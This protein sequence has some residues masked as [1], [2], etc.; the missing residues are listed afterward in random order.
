MKIVAV[1]SCISGI[2]HTYMAA[3]ALEEAAKKAGVEIRVETQGSA[4]TTP[5]EADFL[6]DADAAVFAHEL[7]VKDRE[8]FAGLPTVD[9]PVSDAISGA[10]A[11]V[12]KAIAE[13]TEQQKSGAKRSGAAAASAPSAEASATKPSAGKSI[14]NKLMT[15]VSYMIPFVAAGGILIAIGFLL[16]GYLVMNHYSIDGLNDIPTLWANFNFGD[17]TWWGALAFWTGKAA[18]AFLVPVLAGY[19]AYAIADRPGLAPGFVGGSI[20]VTIGA[21]F[22]GG[23]AAGFIGGYAAYWIARIKL[24]RAIDALKPVVI[25]PLIASIVTGF[26]MFTVVGAPVSLLMTA[27][28]D[29]LSSFGSGNL[30]IL[31]LVLGAMMGLDLGGPV[32]KVAYLFATTGLDAGITALQAQSGQDPS[33]IPQLVIMAAVMAAGM[34]PPLGIALATVLQK[35]KFSKAERDNGKAAWLLGASFIS[36]GAIPFAAADPLRILPATIIGSA[37][38]GGLVGIFGASL[39]APHGGIWVIGLIGHPWL[40][41]LA[42]IIGT[43]VTGA[44]VVAAKNIGAAAKSNSAATTPS[45]ADELLAS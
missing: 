18:F 11:L 21:G 4:G 35:N 31:G 41:L 22:L 16:G 30:L 26:L 14:M 28:N 13:A 36:E 38:T 6:A 45:S 44:V 9:V 33:S 5:I 23:I 2:A 8:R 42:V 3:E 32:N 19:I 15:G 17:I 39:T 43:L 24:P 34:T 7:Q 12:A 25:I 1:T 20:A 27:L 37:V 10:D 29:W 40:F